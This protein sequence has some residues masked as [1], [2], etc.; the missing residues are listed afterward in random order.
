MSIALQSLIF[1][2]LG[3]FGILRHHEFYGFQPNMLLEPLK[4]VKFIELAH[5]QSNL[6]GLDF[7][8]LTYLN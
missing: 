6:D 3:F 4:R 2:I 8:N 7:K 5:L 1:M